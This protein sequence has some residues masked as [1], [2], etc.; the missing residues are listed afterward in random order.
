MSTT[1]M[2]CVVLSAHALASQQEELLSSVSVV[3]RHQ[4]VPSAEDGKKKKKYSRRWCLSSY[5]SCPFNNSC[6]HRRHGGNNFG[7]EADDKC[8]NQLVETMI[9][10]VKKEELMPNHKRNGYGLYAHQTGLNQ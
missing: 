1:V 9:S 4:C 10:G 7:G 2:S 3:L 6:Y 5:F 8:L